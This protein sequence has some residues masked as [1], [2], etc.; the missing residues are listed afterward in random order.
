MAPKTNRIAS[1]QSAMAAVRT[2]LFPVSFFLWILALCLAASPANASVTFTV[3][4]NVV[5]N[6]Y[7]GLV[8]LNING[9][10]NGVT[11]VVVQ[12]FLDINS[13]NI[14]DS[15]D[16]LVQQFRLTVGQVNV[17]TNEVTGTPVT[18][19]NVMPADTSSTTNQMT[20]PLN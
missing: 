19:T 4:P 12:K 15:R 13:N 8:T 11:N 18:V 17:F 2:A 10:T 20:V 5:S 16:L 7:N 1:V 9:L 14:I 6:A 3:T